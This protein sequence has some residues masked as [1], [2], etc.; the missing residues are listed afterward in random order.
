MMVRWVLLINI[1]FKILEIMNPIGKLILKLF[2]ALVCLFIW[3]FPAVYF[4]NLVVLMFSWVFAL[5][6]MAYIEPDAEL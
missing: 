4:D 5:L 2:I 3:I 1:T 6:I